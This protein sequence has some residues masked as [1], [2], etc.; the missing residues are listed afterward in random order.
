MSVTRGQ[1]NERFKKVK[2]WAEIDGHGEHNVRH[3]L[4]TYDVLWMS[5]LSCWSVRVNPAPLRRQRHR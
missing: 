2:W 5:V 1:T 3:D 4:A